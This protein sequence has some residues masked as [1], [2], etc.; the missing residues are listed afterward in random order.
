V[1]PLLRHRVLTSRAPIEGAEI[2]THHDPLHVFGPPLTGP[3]WVARSGPSNDSYH[4]RGILVLDGTASIDRRYAI[5][6]VRIRNG[7][8]FSGDEHNN[9]AYYAYGEMVLAVADGRVVATTDGI[10]DNVPAHEGF[11]PA[12]PLTLQ[13]LAGN[14]ITL[15]VGGSQFAYYMHLQPGSVSVKTGDRVRRGTVL[16]RIG[17]SGDAR[18]PHLHFEVTNSSQLLL[19]EGVPYLIQRYASRSTDGVWQ[20]RTRELPIGEMMIDFGQALHR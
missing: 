14:S 7:T 8:S 6:W 2:G 4:R 18:E 5:D 1:P 15:D 3:D 16:A 9:R 11:R 17:N 12:V 20:I 10:T 13:T 19:G